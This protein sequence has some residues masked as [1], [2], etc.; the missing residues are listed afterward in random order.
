MIRPAT[1]LLCSAIA[2]AQAPQENPF[3]AAYQAYSQAR[4]KGQYDRATAQREAM[5]G[6]L[7]TQAASDPQFAGRSQTLAQI[8]DGDGM[9]AKSRTVLED[10]VA[11]AQSAGASGAVRVSLLVGL[12]S[13]WER[14]RNLLKAVAYMEQAVTVAEQTPQSEDRK[15]ATNSRWVVA[16]QF[17]TDFIAS[18]GA[19]L[20]LGGMNPGFAFDTRSN[21]PTYAARRLLP[22]VQAVARSGRRHVG[23]DQG[24]FRAAR[25][26]R[27]W[28]SITNNTA[29]WIKPRPSIKNRWKKRQPIPG[30]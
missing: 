9:S 22:C 16:G 24:A 11:R 29:N 18:S 6:L 8:Y 21:I 17:R 13:F 23:E 2:V 15:A 7:A 4:Q 20:A 10:A 12:A 3:D 25:Q 26:W 28:L 5:N 14:D 1:L 19:S 30:R 27:I